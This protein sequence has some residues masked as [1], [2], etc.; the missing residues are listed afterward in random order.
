MTISK[1][2]LDLQLHPV[3]SPPEA[4]EGAKVY[5]LLP[6]LDVLLG[7]PGFGIRDAIW[8]SG[9]ARPFSPASFF[10]A[11]RRPIDFH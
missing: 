9:T 11:F 7:A 4:T 6:Q 5:G 1:R 8:I 3:A 10:A 2:G